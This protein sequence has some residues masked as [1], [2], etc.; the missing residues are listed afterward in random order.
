MT[1]MELEVWHLWLCLT[2]GLFILE[3]FIST[4]TSLFIGVSTLVVG[5]LA[6]FD[7][8][9][10]LQLLVFIVLNSIILLVIKPLFKNHLISQRGNYTNNITTNIIG[11]EAYVMEQINQKKGLGKI[12]IHGSIW[13]AETKLGEQVPEGSFVK[14]IKSKNH[15]VTVE[16]V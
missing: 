16:K 6:Y 15:I 14:I 12:I 5:L 3:I 1:I 11:R 10:S 2:L 8:E 9:L 13:K 4:F 7:F